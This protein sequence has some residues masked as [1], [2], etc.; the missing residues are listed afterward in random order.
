M[1]VEAA[2]ARHKSKHG[3]PTR[4]YKP[5]SREGVV[6]YSLTLSKGKSSPVPVKPV[7]TST[8]TNSL[9]AAEAS[10]ITRYDDHRRALMKAV[11]DSQET[12]VPAAT[13]DLFT[14]TDSLTHPQ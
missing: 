11:F 2:Y 13:P 8:T 6:F 14:K 12:V 9:Q 3:G 10:R 7:L 1:S 5:P 4:N